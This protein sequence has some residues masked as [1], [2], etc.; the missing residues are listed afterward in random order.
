MRDMMVFG[1]LAILIATPAWPA[2][3]F[4]TYRVNYTKTANGDGTN[5]VA[6]TVMNGAETQTLGTKTLPSV[7][8]GYPVRTLI[9]RILLELKSRAFHTATV[10][11]I[12]ASGGFTIDIEEL[13][14][15]GDAVE[16]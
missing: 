16:D 1:L 13:V 7:P 14:M 11:D 3:L 2:T 5:T 6:I 15:I 12:S 8:D 4:A 10:A 9:E